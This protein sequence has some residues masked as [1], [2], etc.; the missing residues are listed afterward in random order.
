[1]PKADKKTQPDEPAQTHQ[2]QLYLQPE[3]VVRFDADRAKREAEVQVVMGPGRKVSRSS[4]GGS[5]LH[6][7]LKARGLAPDMDYES[8]WETVEGAIRKKDAARKA[9]QR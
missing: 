5:V 2:I 6:S 8:F 7:Y 9:R 3:L 4:H 1:M